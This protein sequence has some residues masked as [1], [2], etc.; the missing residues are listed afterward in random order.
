MTV[1][2]TFL[3]G[4]NMFCA[5]A[6]AFLVLLDGNLVNFVI[7]ACNVLAAYGMDRCLKARGV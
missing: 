6:N 4:A 5:G 3:F 1:W 2:L 7:G